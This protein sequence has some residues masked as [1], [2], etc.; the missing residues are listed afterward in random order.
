MA[1]ITKKIDE[2]IKQAIDIHFHV[3]PEIIPRK[4]TTEELRIKEKDRIYGLV[5]KNHFYPTPSL[6]WKNKAN[7]KPILFGGIVLNNS[8]GGLN[9]AYC[10]GTV[11]SCNLGVASQAQITCCSFLASPGSFSGVKY[12]DFSHKS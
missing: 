6:I 5:L 9:D 3:G 1:K 10:T 11:L 4:Y 7:N 2:I 8:V 12:P